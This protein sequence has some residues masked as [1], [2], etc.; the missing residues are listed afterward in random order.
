MLCNGP[1]LRSVDFRRI[2]LDRFK[3]FGLNKIYLGFQMLGFQP[4]Y[5]VAI[6]R[7][8][9]EQSMRVYSTLRV[10]KFISDRLDVALMPPDPLTFHL[11]TSDLPEELPRFSKDA[12]AYV[13]EGWTV[14]HAA[15]QLIYFMGFARVYIVGMDH[16]FSQH[17][18]GREN[19]EAMLEGADMDHFHES[20]FGG[21]QKWDLPDLR[22]SEIS[23]QA[24]RTAF[25][26]DGRCIYDCTIGGACN[27]F[28]R[29]SVEEI[30]ADQDV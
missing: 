3:V 17:I 5:L 10:P 21:G 13:H 26:E 1:S 7:K 2:N 23:Y 20:Y 15:L 22:N 28:E 16:R 11:R 6:N 14:T 8:V 27:V 4:D 12:S 9:L 30:Y 25:E 29:R 24:A 18:P 19:D